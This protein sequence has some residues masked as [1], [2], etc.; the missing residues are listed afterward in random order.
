LSGKLSYPGNACSW[1]DISACEIDF[2]TVLADLL[3]EGF[4]LSF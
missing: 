2:K 1:T 4:A 3:G